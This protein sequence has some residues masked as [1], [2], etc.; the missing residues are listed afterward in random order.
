MFDP[1]QL[2][3]FLAV[4]RA[5]SFTSAAKRLGLRQSTVSQHVARLE[6]VAGRKLFIRDTHTVE[7]TA[8]G[9]AMVGFARDILECQDAARRHFE[10]S[11]ISGCL[12]LGVS[13]DLVLHE[14]PIVLREFRRD[15]PL[16]DL[17]LTVGPAEELSRSLEDRDLDL[18]LGKRRPGDQQGELIFRD[19]LVYLA[20]PDF[21]LDME[22]PVPLVAFPSPALTREIALEAL[23]HAGVRTRISCTS[24]NL[25]GIRAAALA[26]LGVVAHA[27]LLPPPGLVEL[28]SAQLPKLGHIEYVLLCR[29][30]VMSEPEQALRA[31]ILADADRLSARPAEVTN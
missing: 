25:N 20:A 1:G 29:R 6:R 12:R 27:R 24:N 31:A 7:L 23:G 18:V 8:D 11:P 4:E 2:R 14:L 21:V 22:N 5:R 28:R 16:I 19:A 3:S 10:A 17:Q 30:S 13:E 9:M 15:H 26:G